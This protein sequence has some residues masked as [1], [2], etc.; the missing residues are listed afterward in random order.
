MWA[1]AFYLMCIVQASQYRLQ[2]ARKIKSAPLNQYEVR[3]NQD[4]QT[5][6][7]PTWEMFSYKWVGEN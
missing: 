5:G 6:F 7:L 3:H 1:Y 2:A 4:C